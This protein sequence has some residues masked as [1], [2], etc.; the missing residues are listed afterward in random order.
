MHIHD[1]INIVRFN[2]GITTK[3]IDRHPTASMPKKSTFRL[4][5][6]PPP[7]LSCKQQTIALSMVRNVIN[8]YI[9]GHSINV[10]SLVAT[11]QHNL[12]TFCHCPRYQ[13][14]HEP[15]IEHKYSL[16]ELRV[17]TWPEPLLV[18]ESM[19]DHK[20]HINNRLIITII[21]VLSIHRIP[22][23][24]TYRITYR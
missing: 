20:Q 5:S 7:V 24:T 6:E 16:L 14:R 10:L 23:N 12:R 19:Q 3:Y 13:C 2:S 22:T 9:L 1:M 11:A 21:I 17:K 15:T 18:T 8:N 4:S